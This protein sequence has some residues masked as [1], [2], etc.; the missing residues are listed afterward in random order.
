MN[1][2]CCSS[3][4]ALRFSWHTDALGFQSGNL[5]Q[6]HIDELMARLRGLLFASWCEPPCELR[7]SLYAPKE[8]A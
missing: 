8:A 4:A 6:A 7:D 3:P 1:C 5:C 2:E